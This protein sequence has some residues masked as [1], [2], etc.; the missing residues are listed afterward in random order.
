LLTLTRNAQWDPA[1]D[2]GRHQYAD[3]FRFTLD[4]F[5]VDRTDQSIIAGRPASDTT[6]V[7]GPIG[8]DVVRALSQA[9]ELVTQGPSPCVFWLAP[10]YRKITDVRVRQAI[11][12]AFPYE[13]AVSATGQIDGVTYVP[14]RTLLPPGTPGRL[15]YNPLDVDAGSADPAKARALL[16]EAGYSPGEYTLSYPVL[17]GQPLLRDINRTLAAGLEAGGFKVESDPTTS[18]DVFNSRSDDPAAP[19]NLR[20]AG[21]C[22]DWPTGAASPLALLSPANASPGLSSRTFFD[23][24]SVIAE[25]SRIGQLPLAEQPAAWAALDK[26]VETELYPIIVKWY[27]AAAFLHGTRIGGINDDIEYGMPTWR[28]MYVMR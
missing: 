3:A 1:T 28:D 11:G 12:Y 2:P 8:T 17:A 7:L 19:Y 21:T 15:L 20:S 9:P 16:K 5:E 24:P 13:A 22:T 23:D 4:D 27:A 18:P 14:G 10:D 6:V 26:S 25:I